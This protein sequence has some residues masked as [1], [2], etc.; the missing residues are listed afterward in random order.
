MPE[1]SLHQG[2]LLLVDDDFQVLES[3]ADWLREQGLA[4]DTATGHAEA[5]ELLTSKSY[6]L[7]LSDVRLGDGDGFDLLEQSLRRR[8]ETQVILLTGYG[9]ADSAIEAIRAAGLDPHDFCIAGI[10]GVTDALLAVQEGTMVSILQDA[11]AQAQGAL[12]VVL[13]EI[14]GPD[15]QP[16]SDIWE[17][18]PDMPWND[19]QD[20]LYNVPWTPVTDDNVEDLLAQRQ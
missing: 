6:D 16:M 10:D 1:P 8:P 11:R 20:A 9:T 18:Y 3:M 14:I 19:G 12:D 4:V 15:Y 7:L 17:L 2:N 13:R 5:L